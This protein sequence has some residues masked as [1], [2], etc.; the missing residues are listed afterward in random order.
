MK[1]LLDILKENTKEKD[2][3][4]LLGTLEKTS[5]ELFFVHRKLETVRSTS[6]TDKT[7]TIYVNHGEFKGNYA[8]P[9]YA[10]YT[11]EEIIEKI[12][13]AKKQ[14]E[15]I[16]NK[17][18]K[19]PEKDFFEGEIPSNLSSRPAEEI[20]AEIADAVFA[21]DDMEGGSINATEIFIYKTKRT[22]DNSNGLHKSQTSAN[23]FIEAIPTWTEN[24][25]SVELYESFRFGSFDKKAVTEE[26]AEKMREVKDR[27]HAAAP[28]E[29]LTCPVVIRAQ[30]IRS[31][32]DEISYNV[33][34]AAVY[35]KA[36]L[37]NKGDELQGGEKSDPLT[38]ELVH[39]IEGSVFSS[40]FD[41]DGTAYSDV[42]IFESG[43]AVSL[44]GGNKFA[45]YL[46]E[47]ITGNLPCLK[48]ECGSVSEKELKKSPYLECVS[49]SGIQVDLA[50]D[51]IG[52][53]VRLAYLHDGEKV[54]PL[55]G[56]TI[57]GSLRGA[58]KKLRLSDES[59]LFENYFGPR[60]AVLYGINI[61]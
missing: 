10:S 21:A 39:E 59:A 41:G 17:Y 27:Y 48:V 8:F 3:E 44:Y 14:A 29:K 12:A 55:T 54:I 31:L 52:G 6:T 9:V 4:F 11:E 30:E 57:S 35:Q 23:A 51:Y 2:C 58:I 7:V 47:K 5:Y 37:L 42:K 20:G 56:I 32:L 24:G 26:I 50:N 46:S 34:Y 43:K 13:Y 53:E 36:N 38:V 45:Q 18:Y 15:K 61:L 22:V 25:E 1:E 40:K 28:K 19:L 49:M 60:F 33:N 16:D